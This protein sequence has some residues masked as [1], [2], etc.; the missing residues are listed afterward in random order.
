MK[1]VIASSVLA[2]SVLLPINLLTSDTVH[3]YAASNTAIA[4][5]QQST[6]ALITNNNVNIRKGATTSYNSIGKVQN[7]QLVTIIDRF[8]N[9]SGEL[10]YKV[11]ADSMT[12]WV[13]SDYVKEVSSAVGGNSTVNGN[14]YVG[15]SQKI[16]KSA[17]NMRSGA[18]TSYKLLSTIPTGT[19][20]KILGSFTNAQKEV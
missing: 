4:S 16:G 9:A 20:L 18:T 12:G 7:G 2:T 11:K 10:W 5:T 6:K 8:T 17:A 3:T 1:K 13:I 14:S 19:S 15:S